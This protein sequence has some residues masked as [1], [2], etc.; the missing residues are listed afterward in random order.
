[1]R[2]VP[3]LENNGAIAPDKAVKKSNMKLLKT[4]ICCLLLSLCAVRSS[5]QDHHFT[6][7]ADFKKPELFHDLPQRMNLNLQSFAQLLQK[8]LGDRISLPLA[9]GFLFAGVVVSKSDASEMR[10]KTV[11]I[12]SSNRPGAALTITGIRKNDGSY[13]YS[14][15]LLSLKHSDAYEMVEAEG[16]F[17][18][19]KKNLAD[20]VSE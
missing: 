15:R 6:K 10:S 4:G 12:K 1:M 8:E 17:A 9:S 5:A 18:L 20:L 2:R 19:E 11:V 13:R 3:S 7:D 16:N 14:G